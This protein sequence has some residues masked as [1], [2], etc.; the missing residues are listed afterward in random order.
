MKLTWTPKGWDD[1]IFWQTTD[2][3]VVKKINSLIK[4]LLRTPFEGLGEPEPLRHDRSGYWSRR[5]NQEHRLIYKVKDDSIEIIQCRYHY[6]K[7]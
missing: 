7:H 4:N 1:Y 5:I 2:K 6:T 3:K